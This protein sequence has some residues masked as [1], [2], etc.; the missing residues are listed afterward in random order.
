MSVLARQ[1][2]ALVCDPGSS[3]TLADELYQLSRARDSNAL[4]RNPCGV[5]ATDSWKGMQVVYLHTC[6]P[7]SAGPD[8]AG[9]EGSTQ[10][11][12]LQQQH[13]Q[14]PTP[15]YQQR[16]LSGVLVA[17]IP[18]ATATRT[19]PIP[20]SIPSNSTPGSVDHTTAAA[21]I[22][23]WD[24]TTASPAVIDIPV[25]GVWRAE[26][27]VVTGGSAAVPL[28]SL[29]NDGRLLQLPLV[30]FPACPAAAYMMAGAGQARVYCC[31]C[32]RYRQEIMP[33]WFICTF[34]DC[35]S[36]LA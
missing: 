27:V 29:L 24:P 35:V 11:Q 32:C 25:G 7:T 16:L 5:Q 4:D 15:Q 12:Q 2:V 19:A 36:C 23:G 21:R 22:H 9:N 6:H 10:E 28:S 14:E 26:R 18:A 8:Q 3:P 17:V 30:A 33:L 34:A 1:P 20:G 31:L 13:Q